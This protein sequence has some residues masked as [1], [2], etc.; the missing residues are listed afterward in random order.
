MINKFEQR[1]NAIKYK[2]DMLISNK[3][4]YESRISSLEIRNNTLDN[5]N[6]ILYNFNIWL[7]EKTK[8]KLE[9]ITNEA[10]KLIFPDKEM[11]FKVIPNQTKKGTS[12]ELA[13]ETDGITTDLLDAKGGGVL[14]V[15]QTCL[16]ITYLLR[17][18]G[19]IRQL[20][21]FDE[22]FK[23]LDSERINSAVEWLVKISEMFDIQM[24][25]ITHIP[26]MIIPSSKMVSYEMR[27]KDNSS[28]I[29]KCS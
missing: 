6:Q 22:P 3:Q 29:I 4:D 28:E 23:N 25:I 7:N 8:S 24:F 20:I 9:N 15:I 18:K 14:D 12:Y 10:L 27:L 2:V 17:F 16:R 21:I 19:S 26:S 5:V 13:I 1:V 11:Y